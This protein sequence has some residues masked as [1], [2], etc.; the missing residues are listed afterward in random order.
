MLWQDNL[1]FTLHKTPTCVIEIEGVIKS[2]GKES[3]GDV[4]K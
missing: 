4:I 1:V 2:E 3:R